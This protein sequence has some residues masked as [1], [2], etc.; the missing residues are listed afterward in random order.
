MEHAWTWNVLSAEDIVTSTYWTEMNRAM[1]NKSKSQGGQEK[2]NFGDAKQNLIEKAQEKSNGKG[3]T[4][5]RSLLSIEES[6]HRIKSIRGRKT[7][8]L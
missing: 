6:E 5:M 4:S 2:T 7:F 1:Y 3:R 8:G